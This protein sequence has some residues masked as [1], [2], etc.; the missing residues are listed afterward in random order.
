[1]FWGARIENP[2]FYGAENSKRIADMLWNH[3]QP[4]LGEG[5]AAGAHVDAPVTLHIPE[6]R[7]VLYSLAYKSSCNSPFK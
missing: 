1:M 2:I 6:E 3:L 5:A 7:S 4:A